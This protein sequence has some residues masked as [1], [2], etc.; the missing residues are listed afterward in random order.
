MRRNTARPYPI[1][2]FR[3]PISRR[4]HRRPARREATGKH[5][6]ILVVVLVMISL[7]TLLAAGYTF[8]VRAE[9]ESTAAIAN[10]NQLRHAA[11]SGVQRAILQLRNIQGDLDAWYSNPTVFR[12]GLVHGLDDGGISASESSLRQTDIASFGTKQSAQ[13]PAQGVIEDSGPGS[14]PA[15]RFNLVGPNFDDPSRPRYG[16]TDETSKL[17]INRASAQSLRRFFQAALTVTADSTG[18]LNVNIDVLVDSLLDWRSP[19]GA[20]REN[21]AKDEWYL[22]NKQPGYRCKNAPFDTVDELL[23]V[24]G[25]NARLL[26]GEDANRNG[27][28]DDNEDDGDTTFPADNADGILDR[29]LAPYLTVWSREYDTASTGKPRINLNMKDV[30]QLE[31]KLSQI[32][33]ISADV[34]DYILTA[35]RSGQQIGDLLSLITPPPEEPASQPVEENFDALQGSDQPPQTVDPGQDVGRPTDSQDKE[36]ANPQPT[37]EDQK[38]QEE[39]Q[40]EQEELQRKQDESTSGG[41]PGAS[42]RLISAD[43]PD[44]ADIDDEEKKPQEEPTDNPPSDEPKQEEQPSSKDEVKSN[45][46]SQVFT[47]G[48]SQEQ[49]QQGGDGQQSGPSGPGTIDDLHAILDNLSSSRFPIYTGRINV[50]TAPRP[51][52]MALTDLTEEQIDLLISVRG[53][54]DGPSRTSPAWLVTQG[55]IPFSTFRKIQSQITASSATFAVESVGFADHLD[56]FKRL[57]VILEMRGPSGQILY[58]RDLTPLGPAYHPRGEDTRGPGNAGN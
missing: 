26:Y 49:P 25:F 51:V 8:L 42:L 4:G 43:G 44:D 11:E 21:G 35:R 17:D 45:D 16:I 33:N 27:L 29:G 46:P 3:M 19:G 40:R 36:G 47:G 6:F 38:K 18:E 12:G 39:L 1:A 28:L 2:G 22:A 57:Y 13:P 15:W 53:S 24:R 50:S 5:A 48:Q 20:A 56:A 54:L 37:D 55:V 31:Q 9:L 7:L 23:L 58:Y 52:L 34:K 32:E 30:N 14:K 41:K 10:D